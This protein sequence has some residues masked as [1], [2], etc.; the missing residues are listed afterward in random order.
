[1]GAAH[2]HAIKGHPLMTSALMGGQKLGS[3]FLKEGMDGNLKNDIQ[4]SVHIETGS[5]GYFAALK[6][7]DVPYY[8]TSFVDIRAQRYVNKK[9]YGGSGQKFKQTCSEGHSK[10]SRT[11]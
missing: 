2:D 9:K 7:V 3:L 6:Q 1:M 4:T 10:F 5:S 11:S 8:S